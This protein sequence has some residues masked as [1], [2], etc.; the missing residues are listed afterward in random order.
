MKNVFF[1]VLLLVS[2]GKSPKAQ[3]VENK[4]FR[5]PEIPLTLVEPIDRAKYLVAHYWD[6]YNFADTTQKGRPEITEQAF[7]DFLQ[8]LKETPLKE[9][10]AGIDTLLNKA[11]A[12]DSVMYA[13]FVELAD[14]YLYDPNSPMYC[15]DYYMEVLRNIIAS[16]RVDEISKVRPRFRLELAEK[17]RVGSVATDFEYTLVN[18]KKGRLSGVKKDFVLLFFND[19]DCH[20]CQRVK[21]YI[22]NSSVLNNNPKLAVLSVFPNEDI[23]LW[24]KTFYPAR[25]ISGSSVGLRN[26]KVYDLRAIPNLYLLD[27]EKRVLIKDGQVEA[28]EQYLETNK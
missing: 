5:L 1:I 4:E 23:D 7:V 21:E 20:D 19:P 18:G 6:R 9:A 14:K 27:K 28:I 15:E 11:M 22:M 2:C 24:K 12:G 13:H 10:E 3:Q 8:V 17:N 26:E 25:W 16:N